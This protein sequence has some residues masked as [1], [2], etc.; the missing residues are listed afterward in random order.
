LALVWGKA[1]T[2]SREKYSISSLFL[3]FAKKHV[4]AEEKKCI[5]AGKA[6]R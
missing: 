1:V 5:K 4:L 2:I 6:K 3:A